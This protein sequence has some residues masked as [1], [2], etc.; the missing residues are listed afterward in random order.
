[1]DM[2]IYSTFNKASDIGAFIEK[3]NKADWQTEGIS[4]DKIRQFL[5]NNNHIL[6]NQP[7]KAL[8]ASLLELSGRIE[9]AWKNSDAHNLAL[10]VKKVAEGAD[11]LTSTTEGVKAKRPIVKKE[12]RLPKRDLKE[13]ELPSGYVHLSVPEQM[14]Y[15]REKVFDPI[16]KECHG[17]VHEM[18]VRPIPGLSTVLEN[19]FALI[20]KTIS[21]DPSR[22]DEEKKTY[23]DA[24]LECWKAAKKDENRVTPSQFQGY[25]KLLAEILDR[26]ISKKD[27]KVELAQFVYPTDWI[28]SISREIENYK[29][30]L[31]HDGNKTKAQKELYIQALTELAKEI[32]EGKIKNEN[33]F[34]DG[35][36]YDASEKLKEIKSSYKGGEEPPNIYI[37]MYNENFAQPLFIIYGNPDPKIKARG[38]SPSHFVDQDFNPSYSSAIAF[39]DVLVASR[40]KRTKKDPHWSVED[41]PKKMLTHDF[42]HITAQRGNNREVLG[43]IYAAMQKYKDEGKYNES[44]ILRDGLF[45]LSHE[46][47]SADLAIDS[48]DSNTLEFLKNWMSF[49]GYGL[50]DSYG[51]DYYKQEQRDWEFVLKDT[52]IDPKDK[53]RKIV[54]DKDGKPFLPVKWDSTARGVT[55]PF[56]DSPN[57]AAEMGKAIEDGYARF[58]EHFF[59]LL[60]IAPQAKAS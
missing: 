30:A 37:Q 21:E 8:Q 54:H 10:A 46:F 41:T 1:M 60:G 12:L 20:N 40:G 25:N 14:Q 47:P 9:K 23:K 49:S 55:R 34:R 59:S 27:P 45:L 3:L 17:N 15:Y 39:F 19:A 53:L 50:F 57:R 16:F 6:T 7:D 36:H 44:T 42:G 51:S 22:S 38:I 5:S 11:T 2:N 56:K 35:G 28:E 24:L 31:N 48:L 32:E 4:T 26:Y 18:N 43:Q 58:W 29:N 52:Y 33:R 13:G